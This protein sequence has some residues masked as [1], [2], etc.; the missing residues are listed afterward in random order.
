MWIV[1]HHLGLRLGCSLLVTLWCLISQRTG[2]RIVRWRTAIQLTLPPSR[3]RRRRGLRT[4][5]QLKSC[6]IKTPAEMIRRWQFAARQT[7]KKSTHSGQTAPSRRNT[8][9]SRSA[10]PHRPGGA[11]RRRM[12]R[13]AVATER[14]R[15]PR[16]PLHC[17]RRDHQCLRPTIRAAF[18][19]MLAMSCHV[20]SRGWCY[21]PWR[22]V[23]R[24]PQS[25][26]ASN[27]IGSCDVVAG[28]N[29][30]SCM[31]QKLPFVPICRRFKQMQRLRRRISPQVDRR[32]PSAPARRCP[33]RG[34]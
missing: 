22:A 28:E 17:H 34:C 33:W 26:G 11:T 14:V 19:T 25:K 9:Q 27:A 10:A 16:P 8:G 2:V 32:V 6:Q 15:R 12:A 31:V 30:A 20:M 7:R 29:G 23:A 5:Q 24:K 3:Q 21:V 1:V 18:A 13:A 4:L